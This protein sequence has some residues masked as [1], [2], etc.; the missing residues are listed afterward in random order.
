[1]SYHLCDRL[2]LPF[3]ACPQCDEETP[4]IPGPPIEVVP[5]RRDSARGQ[6]MQTRAEWLAERRTGL[7]GSDIAPMLG[8]SPWRTPMEVY[9]DKLG[10]LE[11]EDSERMQLGRALEPTI[12]RLYSERRD[13][14]AQTVGMVRGADGWQLANVDRVCAPDTAHLV[15]DPT[16]HQPTPDKY[17]EV[18]R[19]DPKRKLWG[20]E[21]KNTSGYDDAWGAEGTDE[22]PG[23]YLTQVAWYGLVTKLDVWEIAVL[24]RGSQLKVYRYHRDPQLE[25]LLVGRAFDFWHNHVLRQRPPEDDSNP[26]ALEALYPAHGRNLEVLE[27]DDVT[28]ALLEQ[29]SAAQFAI[30]DACKHRDEIK[31]QLMRAIAHYPGIANDRFSVSWKRPHRREVDWRAIAMKHLDQLPAAEAK[32][33]REAHTAEKTVKRTFRFT[34]KRGWDAVPQESAA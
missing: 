27:S 14:A 7:G 8:I 15:Y 13:C 2:G 6:P 16:Q 30:A 26:K 4:H 32:V 9:L 23:Y 1:M 34:R 24:C 18:L 25:E 19:S 33:L 5:S 28:D 11:D 31:A 20:L 21:I 3:A 12:A 22:I 17:L 10:R 29:Y